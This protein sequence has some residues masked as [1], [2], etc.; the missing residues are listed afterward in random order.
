MNP[1]DALK[2]AG[3]F[4]LREQLQALLDL[5]QPPPP[6]PPP[7]PPPPPPTPPQPININAG[8]KMPV[9]YTINRNPETGLIEGLVP[10]LAPT[11][12]ALPQE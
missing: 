1:D 2:M 4:G 3:E 10:Q 7:E 11:P 12:G 9:G 8:I 5:Q 6:P